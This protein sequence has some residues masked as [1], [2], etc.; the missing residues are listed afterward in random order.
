M[1]LCVF[2]W[3]FSIGKHRYPVVIHMSDKIVFPC[4]VVAINLSFLA[5]EFQAFRNMY[6]YNEGMDDDTII[7]NRSLTFNL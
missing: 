3:C 1:V 6:L 5:W 7:E 4:N 2:S